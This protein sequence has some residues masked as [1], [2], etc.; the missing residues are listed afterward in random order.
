MDPA[1]AEIFE[2]RAVF[3]RRFIFIVI[4]GLRKK[5]CVQIVSV[6]CSIYLSLNIT[7]NCFR[8]KDSFLRFEFK[9]HHI[10]F[11]LVME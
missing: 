9:S 7:R 1:I 5:T 2:C 4:S 10:Y 6:F 3:F 8:T 11:L